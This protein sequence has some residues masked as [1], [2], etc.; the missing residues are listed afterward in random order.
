[1]I[2]FSSHFP[3]PVCVYLRLQQEK[4][5][6][7]YSKLFSEHYLNSHGKTYRAAPGFEFECVVLHN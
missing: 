1:M 5:T 4:W 3:V 7:S 6:L 2:I